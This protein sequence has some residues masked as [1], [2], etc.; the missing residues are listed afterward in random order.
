LWPLRQI[1][2]QFSQ[3]LLPFC[4]IAA[5]AP[6]RVDSLNRRMQCELRWFQVAA[7]RGDVRAI[8]EQLHRVEI[9]AAL[10]Q[11]TAGLAPQSTSTGVCRLRLYG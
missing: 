5:L 3:I 7:A 8:Q 6:L 11:S 2:P 9:G 4:C 1:L 10:Q